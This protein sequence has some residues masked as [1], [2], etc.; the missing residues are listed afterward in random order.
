[1]PNVL[2]ENTAFFSGPRTFATRAVPGLVSPTWVRNVR[3]FNWLLPILDRQ[4]L[5]F[6]VGSVGSG[7]GGGGS[8]RPASGQVWPRGSKA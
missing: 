4:P 2:G 3:E 5:P 7:T 8:S 1:M 6:L